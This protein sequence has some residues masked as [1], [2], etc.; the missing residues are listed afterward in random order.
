MH[1]YRTN[2]NLP[3]GSFHSRALLGDGFLNALLPSDF[4]WDSFD[5]RGGDNPTCR[6]H[7]LCLPRPNQHCGVGRSNFLE[8]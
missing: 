2:T 6:E 7:F 8:N 3:R 5:V 4:K 1:D